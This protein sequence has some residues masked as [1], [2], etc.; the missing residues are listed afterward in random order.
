MAVIAPVQ[1]ENHGSHFRA[2]GLR[3]MTKLIDS[4][5]GGDHAWMSEIGCSF[6]PYKYADVKRRPLQ[7]A[8]QVTPFYRKQVCLVRRCR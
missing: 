1:R 3:G 6:P 7:V 4:F 5:T 2:Y 8:W